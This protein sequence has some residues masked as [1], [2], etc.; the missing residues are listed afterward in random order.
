[1][2]QVTKTSKNFY[3]LIQ[4]DCLKVLPKLERE[5]IDL[6]VLDPP[7]GIEKERW[8]IFDVNS[9]RDWATQ[10]ERI[11]KKGGS[12]WMTLGWQIVAETKVVFNDTSLRLRN[13]VIWYRKDG[14]KGN[15][16]FCQSHEHL[17]YYSKDMIDVATIHEFR[18]YLDQKRREKGYSF[19]QINKIMGLATSGGGNS[20]CWMAKKNCIDLPSKMRYLELKK[21]LDLDETFDDLPLFG[22]IKFNLVDVWDDVW[23]DISSVKNRWGHPTQKPLKLIERILKCSSKIGDTVLDFF[24]GSGTTM[25]ACQKLERNCIGIEINP[26]YCETI[27]KRCFGRTFLNRDVDYDFKI[28]EETEGVKED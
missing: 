1:M 10:C 17:L 24:M 3:Q 7:Y 20:Y 23:I 13:W 25:D 4:G 9:T 28:V 21:I 26:E 22:S 15:K 14:W 18:R 2:K 6:I 8:D 16:R 5:S 27:R 19:R 11:L 12:L